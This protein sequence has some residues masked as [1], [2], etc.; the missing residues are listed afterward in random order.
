[1]LEERTHGICGP[2]GGPVRGKQERKRVVGILCDMGRIELRENLNLLLDVLNLIFCTLK[3]YDLN[4]HSPLRPLFI[5][6]RCTEKAQTIRLQG[7]E[8]EKYPL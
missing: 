6:A 5:A 8:K 4:R 3:I 2:T 7:E 1:M